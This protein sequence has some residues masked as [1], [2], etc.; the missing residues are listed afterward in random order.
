MDA[1]TTEYFDGLTSRQ[2]LARLVVRHTGDASRGKGVF[3][4]DGIA[5]GAA[6]LCEEP[7]VAVQESENRGWCF[8]CGHCLRF[9]GGVAEQL[10]LLTQLPVDT[11]LLPFAPQIMQQRIPPVPC[12][13]G[14]DVSYCSDA[15]RDAAL[16]KGHG[17]LCAGPD[18]APTAAAAFAEHCR[19]SN[20]LLMLVAMMYARAAAEVSRGVDVAAAL[21]P[22][23][24]FQSAEWWHVANGHSSGESNAELVQGALPQPPTPNFTTLNP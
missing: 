15:C 11:S 8:G 16:H 10:Q 19:D 9:I 22:F 6:V 7:L 24:A 5:E 23:A 1:A 13:Y 18:T 3:A 14:C 17:F 2:Q 20:D 12:P 21:R 4:V